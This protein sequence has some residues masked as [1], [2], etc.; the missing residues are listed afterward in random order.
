MKVPD[1]N[2]LPI[3]LSP[4]STR[5]LSMSLFLSHLGST[6]FDSFSYKFAIEF[7][8]FTGGNKALQQIGS[9]SR[10]IYIN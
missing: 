8:I 7:A 5:R 2:F 6:F 3:V 1:F 10:N 4:S 9:G